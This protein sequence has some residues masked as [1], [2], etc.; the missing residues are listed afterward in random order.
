M[1]VYD[2]IEPIV[3]AC[4]LFVVFTALPFVRER[5]FT[6][7][8]A[9]SA[10]RQCVW[11]IYTFNL[12]NPKN[13]ALHSEVVAQRRVGQ[14]PE[15]WERDI[16]SNDPAKGIAT[17]RIEILEQRTPDFQA[18]RVYEYG[19][20]PYPLGRQHCQTIELKEQP[21][22]TLVTLGFCG[23]TKTLYHY[24]N[25][26]LSTWN[27]LRKLRR[28]AE[29]DDV[30]AGPPM[31]RSFWVC[32]VL[33][34][35]A[36]GSFAIYWGWAMAFFVSATLVFHEFGHWL[37]M[38]LTGQT[39]PRMMLVPFLGGV[40]IPNKPHVSRLNEAFCF[41]M[42]PGLSVLPSL[43]FL[44]ATVLLLPPELLMAGAT[45][46][47]PENSEWL[48]NF[49]QWHNLAV[50]YDNRRRICRRCREYQFIATRTGITTRWR[51]DL[52]LGPSIIQ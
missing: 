17:S 10:S 32:L 30:P 13:A 48:T 49:V 45:A 37:A 36:V 14:E 19:E 22:G 52:A 21:S 1:N 33:S 2:I 25:A 15:L 43:F 42:G 16:R 11:D 38:R 24:I 4:V 47:S 26:R 44:F 20:T 9:I 18:F 51:S 28:I 8:R 40:A 41:L 50:L 6:C 27:H 34:I 31:G 23:E 12:E 35:L 39:A 7:R 5:R 3:V 29:A 46:V